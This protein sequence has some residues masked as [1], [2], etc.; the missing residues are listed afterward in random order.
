MKNF[1]FTIF[2]WVVHLKQYSWLA[3]TQCPCLHQLNCKEEI[4]VG[5]TLDL[6]WEKMYFFDCYRI[7]IAMYVLT[8]HTETFKTSHL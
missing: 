4:F 3:M 1:R 5:F 7:K 8:M 2:K 6:D